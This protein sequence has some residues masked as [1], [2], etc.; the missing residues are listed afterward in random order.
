MTLNETLQA[1]L[2]WSECVLCGRGTTALWLAL[3][4]IWRRDGPGEVIVPDIVCGSV[5]DGVLLAGFAPVFGDVVPARYTLSAESVAAL[6]TPRTR[7]VIV[8]HIFGHAADVAEIRAAAPGIPIIEDAVQGIGGH[9]NSGAA[10]GSLG[11]LAFLSFDPAKMIGGRGGALFFD[12]NRLA[13]GIRAD[14]VQLPQPL[15]LVFDLPDRLLP[16]NAAAAYESQLRQY[17]PTLLRPFDPSPANVAHILHDWHT[18]ETRVTTRNAQAQRLHDRLAG[19]PLTLPDLRPGDAVWCTT[20]TLPTP[21]LARRLIHDLHRAGLAASALYFPLSQ[22][23]GLL[24]GAA[25]LTHRLV[26]LWVE[27]PP[28]PGTVDRIADVVRAVPWPHS[29]PD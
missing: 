24:T 14:L 16:P 26:N 11:D 9:T 21:A 4:A 17:A 5:L 28:G 6:V 3:R 10:L 29:A 27:A 12:D 2:G 8:A 18:L 7:A 19:L 23:F 25:P 22:M 15:D 13:E 20:L 1:A